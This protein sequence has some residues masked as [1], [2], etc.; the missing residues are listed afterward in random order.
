MYNE[1][2][3]R[4]YGNYRIEGAQKLVWK[5]KPL[6]LTRQN[7]LENKEH[8]SSLLFRKRLTAVIHAIILFVGALSRPNIS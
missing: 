1:I 8:A 2:F 4:E 3:G 7:T 5:T 6:E